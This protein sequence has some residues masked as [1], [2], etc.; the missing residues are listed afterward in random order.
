MNLTIKE[1]LIEAGIKNLKEYG[2]PHVT[3]ENILTDEVY[4]AFFQSML[5]DNKGQ[6][7]KEVDNA[8]DVLLSQ[9]K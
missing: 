3:K 9:I 8:I 6:G 1:K 5:N 2:Y 7:G 4:S